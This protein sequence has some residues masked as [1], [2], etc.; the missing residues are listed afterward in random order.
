M[1]RWLRSLG[2]CKF[3]LFV[4]LTGYLANFEIWIAI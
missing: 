4:S 1:D 3:F 2:V